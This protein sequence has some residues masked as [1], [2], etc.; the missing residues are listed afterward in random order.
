[1]SRR[2]PRWD[3]DDRG[4]GSADARGHLALIDALRRAADEDGWV[5]EAPELHLLPH[6]RDSAAG[7]SGWV[8]GSTVVQPDGTFDVDLGWSGAPDADLRIAVF[9]LIGAI[10]ESSTLVH[11]RRNG[12][13]RIFD[14]VSGILEGDSRFAPHGHTL[15]LRIA[16]VAGAVVP[17]D[18]DD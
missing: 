4:I 5:A 2:P 18:L 13:D 15:R 11:E 9:T 6:L 8:I 10:A 1:M 7:G 3:P 14:V 16:G 12:D 17:A